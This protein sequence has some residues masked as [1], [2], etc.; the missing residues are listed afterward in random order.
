MNLSFSSLYFR[1]FSVFLITLVFSACDKIEYSPYEIRLKDEERNLNG[2]YV[3]QI[4][5]FP[6]GPSDT[7]TFALISDTQ[8]FYEETTDVVK[9][10]NNMPEIDF[11]L[12]GGDLTDFG[13]LKEYTQMHDRLVKLKVP[14]VTVIGNH[15]CVA[16]GK[17][18]FTEMYGPY[19]HSFIKN[20]FKFIFLNTNSLEFDFN[21][22]PDLDWL[23]NELADTANYEKALVLT[24]VPPFSG[25]FDESKEEGYKALMKKY[26]VTLSMHGHDHTYALRQY[27]GDGMNY[28]SVST[29][30]KRSFVVVKVKGD[31]WDV[32]EVKF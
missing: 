24:H 5:N 3:D 31:Y 19:N 12:H 7:L 20:G 4:A 26:N 9:T 17:K 6:I 23:E 22:V 8:G 14:Y 18:V 1:F 32:Q 16:N 30:E 28:L 11:V 25:E 15:D 27:Y 2:K 10:I 21:N 13:L 29:P